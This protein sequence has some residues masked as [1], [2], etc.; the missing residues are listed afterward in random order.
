MLPF[1]PADGQA[2]Y[3]DLADR[4]GIAS[5]LGIG[6]QQRESLDEGLRD[7]QPVE[8]IAVD[9]RVCP[10]NGKIQLK[11]ELLVGVNRLA[12][13]VIVDIGIGTI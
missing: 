1:R 7:E 6:G 8:G 5:D 13:G 11:M 3:L 12:A 10:S 9:W 4:P 2:A